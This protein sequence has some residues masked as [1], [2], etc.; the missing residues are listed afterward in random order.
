MSLAVTYPVNNIGRISPHNIAK[1]LVLF[2]PAMV[3]AHWLADTME[4]D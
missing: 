1:S 4:N 2:M 3:A